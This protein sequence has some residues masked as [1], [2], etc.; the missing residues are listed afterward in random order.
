MIQHKYEVKTEILGPQP[1]M[2]K[3]VRIRDRD[4]CWEDSAITYQADSKH[5]ENII[6]ELDLSAGK[7]A[8][9]PGV[10]EKVNED[11]VDG[12]KELASG[13]KYR[14]CKLLRK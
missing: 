7:G 9:T 13:N 1:E 12:D 3:Q 5:A 14:P 8:V 10:T 6:E 4:I 2:K 11:T